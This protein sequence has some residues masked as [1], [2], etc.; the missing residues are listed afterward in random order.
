M[1]KPMKRRRGDNNNDDG[2]ASQSSESQS[3]SKAARLDRSPSLGPG[4]GLP[5]LP[6]PPPPAPSKPSEP[7]IVQEL[8]TAEDDDELT[9]HMP[10]SPLLPTTHLGAEKDRPQLGKQF[11]AAL[12]SS[13]EA[14]G[15][16]FRF[17]KAP[18]VSAKRIAQYCRALYHFCVDEGQHA[19]LFPQQQHQEA[20][21][22][23]LARL[24]GPINQYIE[25]ANRA[26]AMYHNYNRLCVELSNR[27]RLLLDTLN[28]ENGSANGGTRVDAL[29]NLRDIG[30]YQDVTVVYRAVIDAFI[31]SEQAEQTFRAT[32][33][34]DMKTLREALLASIDPQLRASFLVFH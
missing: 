4:P 24:I 1:A 31:A 34:E 8:L 22:A 12:M 28:G 29:K 14:E 13:N 17:P 25:I 33:G 15:W 16:Y 27:H 9:P 18:N 23:A 11:A 10:T 26:D 20:A 19:A 3:S 2:D 6:P 21:R 30:P 32:I 7:S 5:Q